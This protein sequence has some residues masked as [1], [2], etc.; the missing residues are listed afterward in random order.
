MGLTT[1]SDDEGLYHAQYLF[2][3]FNAPKSFLNFRRLS[4]KAIFMARLENVP[5]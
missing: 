1:V 3:K 2:Y 5:L 4:I